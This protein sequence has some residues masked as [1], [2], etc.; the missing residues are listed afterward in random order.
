MTGSSDIISLYRSRLAEEKGAI[1]KDWGGRL[2]IALIYPN[3][4]RLGMSNLG[5]QIVYQILNERSRVVAER[6]FLPEGQEMSLYL[7]SG[8]PLLSLESQRPLYE[9]DLMAFSISFENDYPNVLHILELAGIPLCSEERSGS[10]PLVM[11]GGITAFLNPEPISP[12]VDVFLLGEAEA[13]LSEF[14]DL[15]REFSISSATRDEVISNLAKNMPGLY[16][17][18]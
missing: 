7:R 3:Y 18:L 10:M 6:V 12:F 2:S 5:F 1:K 13:N 4:Y 8:R 14:I 15:F 11:A 17:P 16:A 9:F